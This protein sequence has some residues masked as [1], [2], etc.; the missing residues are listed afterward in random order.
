MTKLVTTD[1]RTIDSQ[2]DIQYEVKTFYEDLY[3]ERITE[4]TDI[5]H[6]IKHIPKLS[7]EEKDTLEGKITLDEASTALKAM[8]NGKSPGTDGFSAE[9][10]KFFWKQLGHFVVRSLNDAYEDGELSA[11]QKEGL[12]TCIPKADKA[13]EFVKNWRPISLLNVVYKIGSSCIANRIKRFLPQLISEDQTGFVRNRYM[14]DNIRLI[15]DLINYLNVKKMPG[16]L[17][18]IDFEKA[19]DSLSWR[20][21]FKVLKAYNFGNSIC[22]WIKTFYSSIKSANLVNGNVSQWF[23]VERGC[24]QGDPISPYLFI[25]CVEILG[26]MIKEDNEIKGICI[27]EVEHKISQFADDTQLFN[28]GDKRS[29]E[30]SINNLDLFGKASGLLMNNEKTQ[31]IWLGNQKHSNKIYCPNLN[32]KWNPPKFKI[33]GIWF[34]QGLDDCETINYNEKFTEV[35]MLFRI[36]SQRTITIICRVAI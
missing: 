13:K 20:F 1:G 21:M 15:Y 14:G 18:C 35:K 19:F 31:A 4:N 11:A 12:I 33:L 36:W 2:K 26:I 24:R 6:L 7:S 28:I 32:I 5:E 17:L 34:T 25:L 30:K 23:K 9:F 8:Q 10:F 16:L 3:K 29:F 27:G 22:H